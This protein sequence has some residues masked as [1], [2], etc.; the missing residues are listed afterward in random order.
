MANVTNKII[1]GTFGRLWINGKHLANVKEFEA[2]ATANYETVQVNG[3]FAD[4]YRYTGYSIAGTIL[5]HKIDSYFALLLADAFESGTM[6]TVVLDGR[7]SDPDSNG[8]ERVALY[9]VVFD[10]LTILKFTNGSIGE[11]SIPFKAGSFK[12]LDKIAD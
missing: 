12:Y 8:S 3:E 2:K 1:R 9:N 10:E 6:P 4:Q 7:L 11:E 5:L